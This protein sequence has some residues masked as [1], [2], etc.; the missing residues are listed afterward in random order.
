[1]GLNPW[2]RKACPCGDADA[3]VDYCKSNLT[4]IFNAANNHG[5]FAGLHWK[6]GFL[7]IWPNYATLS[8]RVAPFVFGWAVAE[9]T[10]DIRVRTKE[11]TDP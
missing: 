7:A 3:A 9:L 2:R 6:R 10:P 5:H 11:D 1:M 8:H 4:C